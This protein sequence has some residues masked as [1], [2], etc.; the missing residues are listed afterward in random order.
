MAWSSR[1]LSP[2][3]L[4]PVPPGK[5]VDWS[6]IAKPILGAIWSHGMDR[7]FR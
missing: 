7:E 1:S 4:P 5:S 2:L 6:D 3:L